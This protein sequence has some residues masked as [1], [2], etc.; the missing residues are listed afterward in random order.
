MVG[1][2]KQISYNEAKDFLLP[3]HYSGRTPS[4]SWAFGWY[5]KNKLVAVCSFGKPASNSLCKGVCGIE[6]S[7]KVFELNRLC[8]IESLN[9]PLS[10]FVSACLRSLKEHNLI[11]IS[12]SDTRMNHTGYIYQACSFIYTGKTKR[13]TDKYTEG[14]KHCRH[15]DNDKQNGLRKVRSAKHRY[16][17]FAMRD[18]K[19]KK[20]ALGELRYPIMPYPKGENK[21][22]MLGDFLLPEIVKTGDLSEAKR[23]Q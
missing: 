20:L 2:I 9:H 14:N 4:I 23:T 17:F 19:L 21:N 16:I 5:I 6:F 8:R 22:Y 12:Y 18:K 15:Y 1:E 13:R 11:I 3:R 10:S 7:P